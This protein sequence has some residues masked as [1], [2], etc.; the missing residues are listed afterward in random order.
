MEILDQAKQVLAQAER[1]LEGS[2]SYNLAC[3]CALRG[4]EMECREWLIRS[5]EKGELPS[6]KHLQE[7]S[8]L[9]SVRET[10]WFIEFL[11]SVS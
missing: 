6:R 8:D 4:E 5:K 1:I 10:Q 11:D 7:D 9:D 2:G 3:A